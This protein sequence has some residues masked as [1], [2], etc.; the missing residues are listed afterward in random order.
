VGPLL[1]PTP[2]AQPRPVASTRLWTRRISGCAP[3]ATPAILRVDHLSDEVNPFFLS[4]CV[5]GVGLGHRMRPDHA[6]VLLAEA[7][8]HAARRAASVA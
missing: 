2:V 7:I 8:R 6:H 3:S 5:D 4:T 1:G